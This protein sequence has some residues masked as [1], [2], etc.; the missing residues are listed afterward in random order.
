MR[1]EVDALNRILRPG[2]LVEGGTTNALRGGDWGG[3]V[4]LRFQI[5]GLRVIAARKGGGCA[6]ERMDSEGLPRLG[7]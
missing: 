1:V 7:S 5:S 3:A 2:R 4:F 6:A